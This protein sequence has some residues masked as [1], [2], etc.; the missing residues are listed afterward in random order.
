MA[1]QIIKQPNGLYAEYSTIVDAFIM[2]D[3]TA[4]QIIENARQE[5]AD[6]AE[7]RCREA[8]ENADAG[9]I[10]GFGLTWEAALEN[11]NRHCS[12]EDRMNRTKES[13]GDTPE[14][15]TP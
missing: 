14:T 6:E 12:P 1:R 9:K 11:H 3:A 13:A 15:S 5:A 2:T 4:E 7:R 8:I 10:C